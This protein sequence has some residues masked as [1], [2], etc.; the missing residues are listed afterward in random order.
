MDRVWE[1]YSH[2]IATMSLAWIGSTEKEQEMLA[3]VVVDITEER[4][5]ETSMF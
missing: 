2:P 4:R 5:V 1:S 3:L